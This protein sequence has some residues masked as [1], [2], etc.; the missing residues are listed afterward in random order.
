MAN[1]PIEDVLEWSNK[2]PSWKQD[3]LRRLA[4]GNEL[5]KADVNELLGQIKSAAGF[6]L[7]VDPPESI[8]FTR[9]H[10]GGGK[11][12]PIILKGISNVENVNRLLSKATLT[13]CPKA[14]TI[15][16]RPAQKMLP[17]KAAQYGPHRISEK[18]KKTSIRGGPT[19][20]VIFTGREPY[21]PTLTQGPSAKNRSPCITKGHDMPS[22][23]R[24]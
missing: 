24:N 17:P 13:F 21:Q 14:L 12:Q 22:R 16:P 18:G 11:R 4:I 6:K 23:K 9:D 20:P 8:P 15:I 5:S 1:E 3:A 7:P 10:F 2:L 19:R